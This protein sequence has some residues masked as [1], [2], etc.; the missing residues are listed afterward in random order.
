MRFFSYFLLFPGYIC[1]NIF[2]QYVST[3][4]SRWHGMCSYNRDAEWENI[5][6]M[7][8]LDDHFHSIYHRPLIVNKVYL[9]IC[10]KMYRNRILS[11]HIYLYLYTCL[12]THKYIY[13]YTTYTYLPIYLWRIKKRA[14]HSGVQTQAIQA[15]QSL[16]I[17]GE[18]SVLAWYMRRHYFTCGKTLCRKS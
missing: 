1:I 18:K 10:L 7:L 15:L 14:K 13:I 2:S 3:F 8:L 5:L 16:C 6:H 4:V 9:V 17:S 11:L 12:Y